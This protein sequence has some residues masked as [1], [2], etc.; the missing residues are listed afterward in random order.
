M[1]IPMTCL[2]DLPLDCA[3][4]TEEIF[5]P[6]LPVV[7]VKDVSEA[8]EVVKQ[9]PTGKPLIA[10]CY[11]Q[12]PAT[13]DA[14]IAGTRSGNVAV[15]SG[16]QRMLANTDVAFGGVGNSGSGVSLWGTE[17]MQ[18]FTNRKHIIRGKNGFAKSFFS[19]PPP[20]AL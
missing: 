16:P 4:M 6:L 7:K 15:N 13:A 20:A 2:L 3:L 10:Y 19:G 1:S 18:E 5:G 9:R 12:N 14:F 17:C 8:I 11:S